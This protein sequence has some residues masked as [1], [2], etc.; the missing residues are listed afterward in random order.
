MMRVRQAATAILSSVGV[1]V[2]TTLILA[3][4]LGAVGRYLHIGQVTWSFELVGM[5]FLWT[6]A[7]GTILSEVLHENVSMDGTSRNRGRF[8]Q[9]YHA[10]VLL[11]VSSAFVWS[12]YAMLQRTGFMPTPVMRA[13]SWTIQ[14]S[15]LV[16]GIGLGCI[17]ILRLFRL[18]R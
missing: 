16:M 18:F 6:T 2:V 14:S 5:M 4:G 7:I 3:T 9:T 13:P 15:V 12:G 17:A 11:I 8:S 1:A 10:I